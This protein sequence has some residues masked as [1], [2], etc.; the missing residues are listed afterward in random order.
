MRS[1]RKTTSRAALPPRR[2]AFVIAARRKSGGPVMFYTG[3]RFS[4]AVPPRVYD[5]LHK[6]RRAAVT[7]ARSHRH[8]LDGYR[9]TVKTAPLKRN[10][11]PRDAEVRAA[12]ERLER[13]SG[14]AARE[15]VTVREPDVRTAL[16]V[17]RLDGVLY[18]TVRDGVPEKYI[19]KF[20]AKSRPLLCASSDGKSLRIVGGRFQFTEAGIE[21]R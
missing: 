18:S 17:G 14:H 7:L 10:P 9:L 21:D 13:F 20:R 12:A 16:V 4:N 11:S 15:A 2:G 1:R 5:T 3:E 8:A 19:H 6:A